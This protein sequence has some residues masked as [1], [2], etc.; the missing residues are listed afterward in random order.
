MRWIRWVGLWAPVV[1]FMVLIYS[2]SAQATLPAVERLWDKLLHIGAYG[3]FGTL[4]LRAFHAGIRRPRRWR[5]AGAA[6]PR[7]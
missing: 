4:C 5:R 2:L 7:A 1:G 6:I 3:L